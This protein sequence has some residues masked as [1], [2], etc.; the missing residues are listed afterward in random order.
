[1]LTAGSVIQRPLCKD[2]RSAFAQ[3][4]VTKISPKLLP[5]ALAALVALPAPARAQAPP[6]GADALPQGAV[7]R[8]GDLCWRGPYHD[9]SGITSL[10]FSPAGKALACAADYSLQV[11]VVAAG[12]VPAQKIY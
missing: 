2:R 4:P 7:A 3:G 11:L 5:A 6:V 1:V 9:G 12:R 10:A 8:L